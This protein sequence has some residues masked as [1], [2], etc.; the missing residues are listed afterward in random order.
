MGAVL[1]LRRIGHR[2]G[3][4]TNG[5]ADVQRA[6]LAATGLGAWFDA[7]VISGEVGVGKP[8]PHIFARALAAL[9]ASPQT[10]IM[11]GDNLERDVVGARAAG[12]RGVW[13]NR[14]GRSRPAGIVPD[15]EIA[16]LTE[17]PAV[18]LAPGA[19]GVPA[20]GA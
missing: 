17:L 16:T 1:E 18:L 19:H 13:L 3:L 15:L 12:M 20:P 4:I 2:L 5:P 11:V 14:S 9:D 6:K 10:A 8:D 7:V